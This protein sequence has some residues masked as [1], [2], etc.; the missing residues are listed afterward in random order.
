VSQVVAVSAAELSSWCK[1]H[2]QPYR[3]ISPFS[4]VVEFSLPL[5][6]GIPTP[7]AFGRPRV[8]AGRVKDADV[9]P[10]SGFLWTSDDYF[11]ASGLCVRDD[12]HKTYIPDRW[13]GVADGKLHLIAQPYVARVES[14]C[15]YFGGYA[16]PGHYLGQTLTKLALLNWLPEIKHLP[17]A[18]CTITCRKKNATIWTSSVFPPNAVSLFRRRGQRVLMP[19]GCCPRR[20]GARPNIRS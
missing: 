7:L 18:R 17:I 13:H 12:M 9:L 8:F 11:I 16:H 5:A 19:R 4:K 15:I 14:E 3:E 2:A 20:S 1:A 6:E 10:V